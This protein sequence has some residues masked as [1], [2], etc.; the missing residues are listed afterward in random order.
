MD[1]N[2]RDYDKLYASK[3]KKKI[4]NQ[5]KALERNKFLKLE[6]LNKELETEQ[7][8]AKCNFLAH[9]I[10]NQEKKLFFLEETLE[11]ITQDL[12]QDQITQLHEE[13]CQEEASLKAKLEKEKNTSDSLAN[14]CET[15]KVI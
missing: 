10:R 3:D 11:K 12:P 14:M 5:L 6:M 4:F 8:K 9:K 1:K 15:R 7:D 13:K 2:F